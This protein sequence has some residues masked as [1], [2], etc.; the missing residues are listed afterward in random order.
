MAFDKA[1]CDQCP[2]K[3][4]W[5]K[6]GEWCPTDFEVNGEEGGILILGD[7][8]SAGDV[9]GIPFSGPEGALVV[10]QLNKVGLVRRDVSWGNI[11][12]CPWPKDD[13]K[14]YLA[15]HR[16][17]NRRRAKKGEEPRLSPIE[18]CAPHVRQHLERYKTVMPLGSLSTKFVYG[19]NQSLDAV[20]GGPA[21]VDDRK[22]LPSYAPST[23]MKTP[24]FAPIFRRDLRKMVRHHKDE[25]DWVDPVVHFNPTYEV[26]KDYFERVKGQPLA[27]DVETDGIDCLTTDLRC[28]GIGTVHE[29]LMIGFVSIDEVKRFYHADE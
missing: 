18:A 26:A 7:G 28:I 4:Y 24:K 2:L 5:Q 11:V 15:R 9:E 14:T 25:L 6:N 17:T 10:T 19:G 8:P 3:K 20:R 16:A 21:R 12:G 1:K 13:A 29:V 22:V 23:I 27:Y